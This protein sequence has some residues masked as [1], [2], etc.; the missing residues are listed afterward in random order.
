MGD[1]MET[2][3]AYGRM[4]LA[5]GAA[6]VVAWA[7]L[8]STLHAPIALGFKAMALVAFCLMMQ[9]VFSL[10]HECFHRH[11]SPSPRMNYALGVAMSTIFGTAYTLYRVNH[12]GH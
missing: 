11:G 12:V 2:P 8:L 6:Q 1:H 5:V 7:L 10:M 3:S 4:N 9:G